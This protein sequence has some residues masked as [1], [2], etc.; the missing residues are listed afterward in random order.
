MRVG[1]GPYFL[2][3]NPQS[4]ANNAGVGVQTASTYFSPPHQEPSLPELKLP[5]RLR[6]VSLIDT[7][8]GVI[9]PLGCRLEHA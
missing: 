2:I 3:N 9:H 8:C 6:A 4:I 5:L 1:V 7:F